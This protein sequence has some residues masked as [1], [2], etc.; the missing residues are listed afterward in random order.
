[1]KKIFFLLTGHLIFLNSITSQVLISGIFDGPLSG[2]AP[3]FAELYVYET[4]DFSGWALRSY[5]N[6]SI[7]VSNST[8]LTTLGVVPEGSFVYVIVTNQDASFRTYF[9]LITNPIYTVIGPSPNV[10]GNDVITLY[11]GSSNI[12]IYGVIGIDG[13]GQSW[14]YEDG[15]AYRGDN[16]FPNHVFNVGEWSLSGADATDGC[17]TNSTCGSQFPIGSFDG[18]LLP[19]EL[20]N[21]KVEKKQN[22][23]QLT[24]STATETNNDYFVIEHAADG[25]HF[26]AIGKVAGAGTTLTARQYIFIHDS[27][28]SGANYYRLKQV[29]FDRAFEYSRIVAVNFENPAIFRLRGNP[30]ATQLEIEWQ[31]PLL[32]AVAEII[33]AQ[34]ALLAVKNIE[35]EI[36][37][38][39]F[40]VS[41]LPVGHYFIR[42]KSAKFSEAIPFQKL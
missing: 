40:D 39:Q 19:I 15:W 31:E 29:D 2:G 28:K 17:N 30:V 13:T 5:N 18:S 8:S 1:M 38:Q 3:K 33:S 32:G 42:L 4:T 10:N 20:T 9:N 22:K 41:D 14:Y 35:E 21:F 37:S 6:G 12:D 16:T 27:P 25:N 23:A 11:N 24:W 7:N 34:G 26:S 36:L